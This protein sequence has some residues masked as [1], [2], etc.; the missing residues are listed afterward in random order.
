MVGQHQLGVILAVVRDSLVSF[1]VGRHL[2]R[3]F[4]PCHMWTLVHS[5]SHAIPV[6]FRF[7]ERRSLG[8]SVRAP[9]HGWLLSTSANLAA[10]DVS[11]PL[12]SFPT[13]GG[14]SSTKQ[15]YCQ[16]GRYFGFTFCA[17][18]ASPHT[19]FRAFR[20][21]QLS[22]FQQC[23]CSI[24]CIQLHKKTKGERENCETEK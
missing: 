15:G 3:Q 24:N 9:A 1:T 17:I 18:I 20:E 10:A 21:I 11:S 8:L 16:C 6:M 4:F 22:T 7:K 23:P 13:R 5:L 2:I 12:Q 14:A 19:F